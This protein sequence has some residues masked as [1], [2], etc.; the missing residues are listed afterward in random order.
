[1]EQLS[2][3]LNVSDLIKFAKAKADSNMY[4]QFVDEAIDLVDNTK[5]KEKE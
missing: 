2:Q 3:T 1:M 4:E 5:E